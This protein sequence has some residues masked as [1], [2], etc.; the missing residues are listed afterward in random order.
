[1]AGFVPLGPRGGADEVQV[2]TSRL[3]EAVRALVEAGVRVEAQ[4]KTYKKPGAVRLAFSSGEDW[5]EVRGQVDY[6]GA[7]V[8]LST[9][10]EAAKRGDTAVLLGDGTFGLLPEE[11]LAR[12]GVL[13]SLGDRRRGAI[14]F[15]RA[16]VGLLD[17]LL[18]KESSIDADPVLLRARDE[19][20]SF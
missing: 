15:R 8:D 7:A 12:H 11:W 20:R 13:A 19:L 5:F 10:L 14:R 6:E 3:G 18:A 17:V 16:Q 2:G 4:G 9:L 1:E